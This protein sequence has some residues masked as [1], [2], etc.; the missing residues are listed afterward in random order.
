MVVPVQCREQRP[1][2]HDGAD[3]EREVGHD[4]RHRECALAEGEVADPVT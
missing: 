3:Q 1:G 4:R 2:E